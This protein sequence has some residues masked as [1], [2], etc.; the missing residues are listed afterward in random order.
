MGSLLSL[1]FP[2]FLPVLT[3]GVRGI[4]AKISGG[5]GGQPQNVDERVKLME[6]EAAKMAAMAQLDGTF[7]GQPAQWIVNLRASFRYII[8]SA[9]LLFTGI[10]VFFPNIVGASV[11]AVFLDMTGACMSFTIGERLYLNLKK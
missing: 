1:I 10:I 9:I 3:D 2:A 4:F 6:A 11:I 5:A 8:I 7:T